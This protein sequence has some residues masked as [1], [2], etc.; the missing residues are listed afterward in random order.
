MVTITEQPLKR[1]H[2][3]IFLFSACSFLD[4]QNLT[5]FYWLSVD[6]YIFQSLSFFFLHDLEITQISFKLIE[7]KHENIKHKQNTAQHTILTTQKN[8]NSP[9]QNPPREK[10]KT[11]T[12]NKH[13]LQTYTQ[14]HQTT[15]NQLPT[16]PKTKL[17]KKS[18]HNQ[19]E[20]PYPKTQ[21]AA[22]PPNFQNTPL[23]RKP[24]HKI[25]KH[26]EQNERPIMRKANN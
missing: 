21:A 6:L 9:L 11:L 19:N 25:E 1:I 15:K 5:S 20:E 16:K 7:R 18:T 22:K 14:K 24:I 26:K 2:S 23:N 4:N 17:Q 12:F 10:R 3:P 8:Q 13:D